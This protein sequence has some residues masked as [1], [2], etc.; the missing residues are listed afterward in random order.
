MMYCKITIAF[1]SPFFSQ[2]PFDQPAEEAQECHDDRHGDR[3]IIGQVVEETAGDRRVDG[4]PDG[5]ILIVELIGRSVA[6]HSHCL[7]QECRHLFAGPGGDRPL[8]AI[9]ID[10]IHLLA[11]GV[12]DEGK[13]FERFSRGQRFQLMSLSKCIQPTK[14]ILHTLIMYQLENLNLTGFSFLIA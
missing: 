12:M 10:G 13:P 11:V 6:P 7:Q 14:Y 4:D 1:Y 2:P 9:A 5:D 8:P 3:G